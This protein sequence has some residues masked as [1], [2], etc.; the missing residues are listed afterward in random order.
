MRA[1]Y[2]LPVFFL[3]AACNEADTPVQ[4]ATQTESN[5][6]Q[7]MVQILQA[8]AQNANPQDCYHLNSARAALLQQQ[9]QQASDLNQ[10]IGLQF[11]LCQEL[12]NA[13]Q[14]EEAIQAIA[15]LMQQ[16][17]S[18]NMGLNPQTKGLYELLAVAYLR[19]GERDNCV[20]S[21]PAEACILPLREAA[22]HKMTTGSK[23]A[24]EVY[25]TILEAFPEDY[26]SRWLLN[27]AYMT[28]GEYPQGVPVKYLIPESTFQEKGQV[29]TF[30]NIAKEAGVNVKGLS[31]GVC[32]DDFNGDGWQDLF[33]TSYGLMDPVRLFFNQGDGTFADATEEAGLSGLVSGLNCLHA[34]YNNDGHL[35][36]F[37]LRGG[38]LGKG[39]LHPNS[40]LK[41]D[42]EGH[43]TD[44]T[45]E[46]GLFSKHPTQT[47]AWA[48]FNG[49]GWL[50]LFIGNESTQ[51]PLLDAPCEL[52]VNQGDGTFKNLAEQYGLNIRAFVK[53]VAWGDINNDQLP[54]LYI[55]I[56]GG[57]NQL[58]IN[59][60]GNSLDDW[61]F[62][63]IATQAGVTEPEQSF[64]CWFWDWNNDGLQDIFVSGYDAVLSN[65]VG[66]V[67]GLEYSNG[68]LK[69]ERPRL[70]QNQGDGTFIEISEAAGLDKVFF[71]MGA[72]YGDLDNDGFL[73]FYIG[74]GAPDFRS[75][76]PNR[77][78]LNESGNGFSEITM[79]GFGHIQKGHGIAFGDI[80]N[81][82]DQDIYCVMGGA[83][84]GDFAENVFFANPGQSNQQVT[85]ELIGKRANRSAV[86]ARIHVTA[87]ETDG[88]ERHYYKTVS[89]GGS[90]GS[91][92]LRQTIGIG[93]G[94][95]QK[96]V[97]DWPHPNQENTILT[98]P[99]SN[100]YQV[101]E[102]EKPTP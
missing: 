4:E 95:V 54:D 99:S 5:G 7:E 50:D 64:P 80:N 32:F 27:L 81:D 11:A 40:L 9:V 74:T 97:I 10:Q 55:S 63:E 89:T 26:Q 12:L 100:A 20:G 92:S 35:D 66:T 25:Q 31:G 23:K 13:G 82:G 33:M 16:L 1:L 61:T 96:I 43:F 48:D 57:S 102:G 29:Q 47:A 101:I 86:G 46:V 30:S 73:D 70:Y 98:N 21:G 76:V 17:Q 3:L 93:K 22:Q 94:S 42:G 78:F 14:L 37:I 62:E 58:W 72:N 8:I 77:M 18:L 34:D 6:T 53:G 44:V 36:I 41:N 59:R 79:D 87:K 75:V 60:G 65:Q 52:Y 71:G 84:E 69:A 28:L 68:D 15:G 38:W 56:L 24:I 19:L 51:N 85:L 67:A 45:Q 2:I 49:D 91:S 88:R 90:F 39:G 83:F